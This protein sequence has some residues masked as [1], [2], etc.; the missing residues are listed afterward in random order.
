MKHT[1][2]IVLVA[3]ALAFG[4]GLAHAKTLR[5]TIIDIEDNKVTMECKSVDGLSTGVDVK[6]RTSGKKAIE[7]C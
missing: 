5:C 2:S 3:I 1:L 7:G 6:L 4:P